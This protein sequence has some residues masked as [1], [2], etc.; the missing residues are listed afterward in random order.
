M[1]GL[2]GRDLVAT[3]PDGGR[4]LPGARPAPAA[5]LIWDGTQD[6]DQEHLSPGI[7]S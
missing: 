4:F 1:G 3:V 5:M 7:L 6:P 2:G